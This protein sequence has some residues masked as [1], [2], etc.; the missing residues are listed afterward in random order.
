MEVEPRGGG[1]RGC[2]F[3]LSRWLENAVNSNYNVHISGTALQN[4]MCEGR[5]QMVRPGHFAEQ[6]SYGRL[7]W[8]HSKLQS[9]APPPSFLHRNRPFASALL[10]APLSATRYPPRSLDMESAICQPGKLTRTCRAG[11]GNGTYHLRSRSPSWRVSYHGL[12]VS[13]LGVPPTRVGVRG[14]QDFADAVALPGLSPPPPARSSSSASI[15][16]GA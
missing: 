13:I 12:Y 8:H 9:F 6:E 2:S 15:K 11:D 1:L 3:W 10:C 7:I 5:P 4:S 16:G 14:E